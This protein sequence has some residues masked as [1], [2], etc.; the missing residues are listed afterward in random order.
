V[1]AIG[2]GLLLDLLRVSLVLYSGLVISHFGLQILYAQRA[3][4]ASRAAALVDDEGEPYAPHVDV[5]VACYKEDPGRLDEC[6]TSLVGQDYEGNIRVHLVDDGSPNRA[7]LL[8]I[9][10]RF[11]RREGW[12]VHLLEQNVGKRHAQAAA[13]RESDSELV[14]TIDSDTRIAPDGIRTIVAAFRDSSVGAVTGNVGVLNAKH[15][16]LTR[17]IG[18]RYWVAFNQE[19][20]A[21]SFFRT[22]LCCSGPFSVYR[23]S[24]LDLVWSRYTGQQFR[25]VPCTYG[26]D[27]HLTN[28]VLDAGFDT[29]YEPRAHALTMAPTTLGEYLKQQLRWNKSFYREFLWTFP[30]MLRRR[31]FMT[32]DLFTQMALPFLLTV[33]IAS[34]TLTA[35]LVEP[36]QGV[37]YLTTIIAMSLV[38]VGYAVARTH[39]PRFF[40]FLLYGILHAVLLVPVRLRALAT[41]TDNAWGTRTGGGK[42]A[43]K[44]A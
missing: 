21:Q 43:G 41:L 9:Y 10:E 3:W 23:R 40:L 13:Y 12:N 42:E 32:F 27:R 8:P 38:R 25:G 24:V 2:H 31:W 35:L 44:P 37:Y 11:A 26:D 7:D 5:I 15:N 19:R 36:A 22:V 33:A 16:V 29:L 28:L 18:F 14:V 30:F 20:A 4:R 6:L 39:D 17:L 34:A 1:T